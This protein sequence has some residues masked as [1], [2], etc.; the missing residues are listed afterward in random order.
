[1][2]RPLWGYARFVLHVF[3]VAHPLVAENVA[4]L[5]ARLDCT[6]SALS[7]E[8]PLVGGE[9]FA[10]PPYFQAQ[11]CCPQSEVEKVWDKLED[12]LQFVTRVLDDQGQDLQAAEQEEEAGVLL[13]SDGSVCAEYQLRLL[14]SRLKSYRATRQASEKGLEI[15][16]GST[17]HLLCAA[18]FVSS[19]PLKIAQVDNFTKAAL[20]SL[21]DRMGAIF[22]EQLMADQPPDPSCAL[23]YVQALTEG[24]MFPAWGRFAP[25]MS[26]AENVSLTTA[27]STWMDRVLHSIV[28][29]PGSMLFQ[30]TLLKLAFFYAGRPDSDAFALL[31]GP[32]AP[33]ESSPSISLRPSAE[34]MEADW[35]RLQEEQEGRWRVCPSGQH[36]LLVFVR[37]AAVT[38]ALMTCRGHLE[39]AA[40][41]GVQWVVSSAGHVEALGKGRS[42]SDQGSGKTHGITWRR[43]E[44][45]NK[46]LFAATVCSGTPTW[47]AD[48]EALECDKAA[49]WLERFVSAPEQTDLQPSSWP[50]GVR[51]SRPQAVVPETWPPRAFHE[52]LQAQAAFS[53]EL[54]K[55]GPPPARRKVLIYACTAMSF[56][57]GHGDRLNG[58]LG[59][60]FYIDSQRPVP[61]S[62]VLRPREGG[63]DW[64]LFGT[65]AVLSAG[66]NFNDNLAAFEEDPSWLLDSQSEV[67]RLVSNQRLTA[68][69]LAASPRQAEALGLSSQP[70]LHAHLFQTLFEPSPA[71][72]RRLAARRLPEGRRIGVHFRAGDQMP[73]QW[74]D[75]PRHSLRELDEFLDCAN[76]LEKSL[77]WD[78][79]ILLFADTDKVL[80]LPRVQELMASG[81]LVWPAVGDSIVHLDR[82]PATLSVRGLLGTW[83]DWWTLA[84]DVDALVLC[85]SGFGATALD[86][87]PLR[88]AAMGKGC[89]PAEGSMG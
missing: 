22:T 50:R 55:G 65:H 73:N 13:Q 48:F 64:R 56:C 36:R 69:A 20:L 24:H 33:L 70:K 5:P 37:Q 32:L 42:R 16:Q 8:S 83:A 63:P 41:W 49:S 87:G 31:H 81:K 43:F 86:I 30:R 72:L 89:V 84:F 78:A 61:L 53:S 14:S 60:F 44:V 82:S 39:A 25:E 29:L 47:V 27:F 77:G 35:N 76:S 59:R 17:M 6:R 7:V 67:L 51:P 88:P 1:M 2:S 45:R 11:T 38:D 71:L 58:M 15:L 57:G 66:A 80:E 62:L 74:K 21:Q 79:T 85:H 34:N 68:A 18:C 52:Y 28:E 23:H 75:P 3:T 19:N 46:D 12:I 4:V 26:F 10:C 9:A 54:K 40:S